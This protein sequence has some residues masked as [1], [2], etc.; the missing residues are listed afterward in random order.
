[1]FA[2]PCAVVQGR[3]RTGLFLKN[4]FSGKPLRST[5]NLR[6]G[7]KQASVLLKPAEHMCHLRILALAG[8]IG[9]AG[10]QAYAGGSGLNTI[11]IANQLSSNSCEVAN[12][13]CE[14]RQVPPD[15][16]LRINW[17]GGNL[18][19]T[20]ADFQTNLLNPLLAML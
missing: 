20:S 2:L 4:R 16:L 3:S 6:C 5:P 8:L 1:M 7:E 17:A 14:R 9:A 15:N 12:Y 11:V 18:S 19:W 13:Y 10:L